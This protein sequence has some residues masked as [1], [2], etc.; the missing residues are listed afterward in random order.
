[1]LNIASIA[2]CNGSKF[3]NHQAIDIINISSIV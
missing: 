1:L 2:S 3:T